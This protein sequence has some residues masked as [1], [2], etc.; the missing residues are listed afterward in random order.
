MESKALVKLTDSNVAWRFFARTPSRILRMV[1]ICEVVDQFLRKPFC[2]FLRMLSILGSRGL[3]VTQGRYTWLLFPIALFHLPCGLCFTITYASILTKTN[4]ITRIF[5]AG[6]RTA[7]RPKFITPKSQLFIC[8]SLVSLQMAI[9]VIWLMMS[10][11]TSIPYYANRNDHQYVRQLEVYPRWS[12]FYTR[13][14]GWTY[15]PYTLYSLE[16][17]QRLSTSLNI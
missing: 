11:P 1:N 14:F 6:K 4:R 17:Y 8:G 3:G 9:G 7:K 10:P 5:R 13:S 2:F 15:V 16:R 12:A